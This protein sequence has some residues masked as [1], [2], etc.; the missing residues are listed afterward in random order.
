MLIEYLIVVVAL[1]LLAAF[2]LGYRSGYTMASKRTVILARDSADGR[3][4]GSAKQGYE[5]Y[6]TRGN[7]ISGAAQ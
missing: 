1:A 4:L 3:P 6:F 2:G 7:P 5:P